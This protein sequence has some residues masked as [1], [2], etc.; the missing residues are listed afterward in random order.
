MNS[1]ALENRTGRFADSVKLTD[2]MVTPKGH[3]SFGYTY[4]REP[5]GVFEKGTP[6]RDPRKLIDVSIREIAAN[7]ALG[8]FY[9]RRM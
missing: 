3:P 8:R 4:Q 7:M 2:A 1:P 5:Y 9:T 6:E